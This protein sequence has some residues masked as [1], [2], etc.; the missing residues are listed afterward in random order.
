M[1]IDV[2]AH[3]DPYFYTDAQ[4]ADVIKNAEQNNVKLIIANGLNKE[5]NRHALRLAKKHPQIKP[6]LG[7]YPWEAMM[8]D[9]RAGHYKEESINFNIE[10]ELAFIKKHKNDIIAL[11]EVGLDQ[12]NQHK[13]RKQFEIFEEIIALSKE[14]DK[15]LI[16]H[17][18]KAEAEVIEL[19]EKHHAK[20]VIM[21]CF[22]GKKVLWQKIKD[23][24]WYCSIPTNCVRSE[25]FQ[26]LI[27]FMPINLLFGET[28]SPFLAPAKDAK[29]EPANVVETYKMIAKIKQLELK[30]VENALFQNY[31]QLL[32]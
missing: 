32:L 23:N 24:Q 30:E 7:I 27:K 11:G 25:H 26:K 17:S 19:L 4:V 9:V 22:S 8:D 6:A 28:D 31:Q 3:L 14:I 5:T 12:K 10:E 15:P 18:R 16:I 20:K 21:H 29:N 1:Y 13:T 2:H